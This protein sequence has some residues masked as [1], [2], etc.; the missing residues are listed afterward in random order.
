[1]TGRLETPEEAAERL[2]KVALTAGER[3]ALW[4]RIEASTG[5]RPSARRWP[6]AVA[7]ALAVAGGLVL[8]FMHDGARDA[9]AKCAVDPKARMFVVPAQC[10]PATVQVGPDEWRLAPGTE[11]QRVAEGARLLTG[12]VEFHV[13][14]RTAGNFAVGIRGGY[15]VRVIG[16]VFEL[17]VGEGSGG[18]RRYRAIR[19]GV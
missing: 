7:A 19:R 16:T 18:A 10:A 8:F 17:R 2:E 9:T 11:I 5:N 1:M 13:A 6:I 15:R 4:E 14:K 12:R 3:V